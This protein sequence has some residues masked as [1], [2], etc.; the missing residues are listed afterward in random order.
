MRGNT[1]LQKTLMRCA[2]LMCAAMAVGCASQAGQITQTAE[3][4]AQDAF[5]ERIRALC[6]RSFAG[7]I[8]ADTPPPSANDPF[9]G[10][11]LVMHVRECTRE[12]IR[13]PFH[14]GEDRSRTWVITRTGQG[15]RLKH[16][17][18]HADGSAD[19]LT[20]YGG[21]TLEA[22]STT[23]Q[24]FPIDEETKRLFIAEKREVSLSNVWAL[25]INERAFVYELSRPNR[26][27]RVRFDLSVSVKTPPAPWGA[28]QH[29]PS[30]H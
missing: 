16:D 11:A 1:N 24:E 13:I 19:S 28:E 12:E 17:H 23:R 8:V 27:F 15:L 20:L 25:E 4:S 29:A 14:V 6:G 30:T 18:R 5:F 2:V 10:K 21:D 3:S 26:L 9:T 22:G 7:E